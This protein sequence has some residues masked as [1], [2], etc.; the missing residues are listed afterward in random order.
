MEKETKI[1]LPFYKIAYAVFFV[2]ILS[3]IRGVT[4]TYEVGIAIEA[5]LAILTTVFCADTYVQEIMSKRSEVHRLYPIKRR[6]CSIMERIMIQ[7]IFLL[8]LAIAGYGLFFIV[9]KPITH[10]VTENET[11]Q[12]AVY[13]FAITITIF[14]WGIL[15]N[16]LSM[17]F[18]N[19]WMGIGGCLLI[20][21]VANSRGGENVFGAWNLFSYMFR[22]IENTADITW[23]YGKALYIC[24]GLI[25]LATLPNIIR[26]RG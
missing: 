19:M 12:F 11:I 17:F 7:E 10:P 13:C 23:L 15:V 9:Q 26:R 8:V 16:T 3:L 25:L 6:F 24:I 22:N 4:H 2:I 14:F 18:R 5:P 21:M 1:V 20:W